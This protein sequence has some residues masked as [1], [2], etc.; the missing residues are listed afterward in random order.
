MNFFLHGTEQ[1]FMSVS[2]LTANHKLSCCAASH[3][4]ASKGKSCDVTA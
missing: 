1:L 4:S 3:Y 2:A